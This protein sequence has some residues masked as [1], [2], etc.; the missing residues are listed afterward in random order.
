[1]TTTKRNILVGTPILL[2]WN[3]FAISQRKQQYLGTL[4]PLI[5]LIFII[6]I[7]PLHVLFA[8]GAWHTQTVLYQHRNSR[9]KQI[10]FQLQ[11]KGALGYNK[12][13]VQVF[14]LTPL[15]IRTSP[16]PKKNHLSSEWKKVNLDCN[17]LGL[18]EP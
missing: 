4:Y 12:R 15:F 1:M 7:G 16:V 9:F 5:I 8:S 13:I 11:D 17:E 18:K 14:Y 10:E 3:Y 2:L 6:V